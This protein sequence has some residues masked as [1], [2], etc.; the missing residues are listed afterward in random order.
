[1]IA[2]PMEW[3]P[4]TWLKSWLTSGVPVQVGIPSQK[5]RKCADG[6]DARVTKPWSRSLKRGS[7]TSWPNV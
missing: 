6:G 3:L 2:W 7:L 1:M 4:A 5:V